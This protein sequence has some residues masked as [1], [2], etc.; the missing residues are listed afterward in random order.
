MRCWSQQ[1]QWSYEDTSQ[2]FSAQ[3]G[4]TVWLAMSSVPQHV[5]SCVV[6]GRTGTNFPLSRG[7]GNN[8]PFNIRLSENCRK[9][10]FCPKIF[11]YFVSVTSYEVVSGGEWRGAL[12]HPKFLAVGKCYVQ[13]FSPEIPN[14]GWRK[15]D[16]LGN[17][18]AELEFW[19]L[20]IFFARNLPVGIL[21]KIW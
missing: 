9:I 15:K 21:S 7:W 2:H 19:A 13:N 20:T 12:A 17:F 11:V 18:G 5:G 6:S 1:R 10:I 3:E 16:F 14:S 4:L 8:S